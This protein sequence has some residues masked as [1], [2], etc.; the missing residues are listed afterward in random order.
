MENISGNSVGID[1]HD[2]SLRVHV[3]DSKGGT[4]GERRCRNEIGEVIKF[5]SRFGA[6]SS[7]AVEACTGSAEFGSELRSATAWSVKLCHP[8]YV[9]RMRHN[10]DK[11]DKSDAHLIADLGR[12]GYLPEVW[13]APDAIRDLL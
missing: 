11:S 3:M 4:Y 9:Q 1:Y 5:V 2:R 8:G 12:V 7:V 6:V 10:P 13:L